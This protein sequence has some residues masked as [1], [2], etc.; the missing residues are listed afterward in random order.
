M[1]EREIS[2]TP[3][4]SRLTETELLTY[5][6]AL[7]GE[8]LPAEEPGL[9]SLLERAILLPNTHETGTYV[10]A[11]PGYLQTHLTAAVLNALTEARDALAGIPA[12]VRELEAE[13]ERFNHSPGPVGTL[14]LNT[15]PDVNAETIRTIQGAEFEILTSQPGQRKPRVLKAALP[16]DL[17][18]AQRGVTVRTIYRTSGRSNPTQRDWVAVMTQAGAQVRT[19]GEDFLRMIIVDRR[20]AFFEVYGENGTVQEE[21]AAWYTQDRSVCAL[22][23]AHFHQQWERA[24]PWV[25]EEGESGAEPEEG[26]KTTRVQ[27]TILRGIVAG[28][29]YATI[30][31]QLGYSERT[32]TAHVS[33]LREALGMNTVMQVTHWWA[34]SPERLLK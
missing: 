18:A 9:A 13:Q 1:S 21:N 16:R 26:T 19:L 11:Q 2:I 12:H 28:K 7:Q 29:S 30:S 20:H 14:L 34:T 31:Q 32:V 23:A 25:P 5:R 33:T 22:L 27:R 17:Q 15:V 24:D 6:K 10:P 3:N 4:T 8:E